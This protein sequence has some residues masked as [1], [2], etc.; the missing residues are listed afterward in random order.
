MVNLHTP[1]KILNYARTAEKNLADY[2]GYALGPPIEG[3]AAKV[4]SKL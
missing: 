3:Q 1:W 4:S 2:F